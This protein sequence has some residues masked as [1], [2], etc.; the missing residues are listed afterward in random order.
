MNSEEGKQERLK[1]GISDVLYRYPVTVV[2]DKKLKCV[3]VSLYRSM[4]MVP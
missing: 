1:D 2:A 4:G 3:L